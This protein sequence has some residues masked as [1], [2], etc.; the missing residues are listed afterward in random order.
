MSV[1]QS[2]EMYYVWWIMNRRET[3]QNYLHPGSCLETLWTTTKYLGQNSP[4]FEIG[5]SCRAENERYLLQ[6]DIPSQYIAN[7]RW[8]KSFHH[9]SSTGCSLRRETE[10]VE[11]GTMAMWVVHAATM[12]SD[13]WNCFATGRTPV[14]NVTAFVFLHIRF[15]G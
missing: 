10:D 1:A 5:T 14:I 7:C 15:S 9:A 3:G 6:R 12:Q 4:K 13:P 2:S 11:T 8:R